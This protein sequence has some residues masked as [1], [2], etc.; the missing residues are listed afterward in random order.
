MIAFL[1]YAVVAAGVVF[2][3]IKA[4]QYVDMIDR[5]TNLSG[6][7]LG[8]VLLSAVT[9]L[10]ELFTS[11]SATLVLR[12]PEMCIGNILGSNLFNLAMLCVVMLYCFRSFSNRPSAKGNIAVAAYLVLI[13]VI[14]ALDFVG[15][16]RFDIGTVNIITFIFIFIYIL[17]VRHLSGESGEPECPECNEE[18]TSLSL[19]AIVVRFIA[20]SIAIIGL[21]ITMTY[22]TDAVATEFNIGAGFAGALLLGVATSLPEV[23][24]TIALFRMK[25]YDIAVGNIVGSN[26]FNFMVLCIADIVS[27]RQTVYAYDDPKVV[28]LLVFGCIATLLTL[29]MLALRSRVVRIICALIITACYILFLNC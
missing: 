24:S 21:S 28:S 15:I 5:T 17:A 20:A 2:A 22:V 12:K 29:P 10:P 1:L 11:L 8:G 3:S 14:M 18:I 13:Y 25:N 4:S 26:L 9:S 16:V 19:N 23:S 7:F 6:A 27:F